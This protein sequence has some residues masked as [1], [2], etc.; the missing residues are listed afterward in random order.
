[1]EQNTKLKNIFQKYASRIGPPEMIEAS[2]SQQPAYY[3]LLFPDF[4][5]FVGQLITEDFAG[6]R[7][8][9]LKVV[10]NRES[11]EQKLSAL[12]NEVERQKEAAEADK[13]KNA[14]SQ[15]LDVRKTANPVDLH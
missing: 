2:E 12:V 1:M 9:S 7:S 15:G 14:K 13:E 6:V 10:A 11:E 8:S 5:L 4:L 3:S